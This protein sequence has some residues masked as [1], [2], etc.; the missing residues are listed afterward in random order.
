MSTRIPCRLLVEGGLRSPITIVSGLFMH[1]SPHL[2]LIIATLSWAGNFVLGRWIHAEI[3]PLTLTFWRWTAAFVIFIPFLAP[4]VWRHR[5]MV[6]QNAPLIV[7][8]SLCGSVMFHSFTYIALNTTTAINAS[9]MLATMPMVIPVFSYLI[10]GER[11]SFAQGIG[12]AISM[13]GV[14]AIITRLD[15]AVLLGLAFTPGDVWV[16]GA[17][18]AWSVYS[19]LLK[20]V[21]RGLPPMVLLAVIMGVAAAVL[22]PFYAWEYAE[23]GPIAI[24]AVTVGSI[25]YVAVFASIIAFTCWNAAVAEVG[26]NRAGLYIHLIPLFSAMLAIVLIGERLQPYHGLGIALIGIGLYL[27]TRKKKGQPQ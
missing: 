25:A 22:A 15:M 13:V 11:L 6:M 20:R 14:G 23:R 1:L 26:P 2:L 3:P 27:T 7:A 17:V 4:V 12:I 10:N 5:R 24:N 18:I 16:L 9:L 19:V 8:L 21:P